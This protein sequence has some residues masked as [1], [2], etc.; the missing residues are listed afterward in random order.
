[1]PARRRIICG[2]ERKVECLA[3][4]PINGGFRVHTLAGAAPAQFQRRLRL[5]FLCRR[6]FSPPAR[7]VASADNN[8]GDGCAP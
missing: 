8:D 1:M 4:G 2:G 3:A 5:G 7:L 6:L